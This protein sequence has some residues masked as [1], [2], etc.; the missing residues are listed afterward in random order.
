MDDQ[1]TCF[2]ILSRISFFLIIVIRYHKPSLV[3]LQGDC[4]LQPHLFF[5]L[6]TFIWKYC[7]LQ[8][9]IGKEIPQRWLANYAISANLK[10]SENIKCNLTINSATL[11][12]IENISYRQAFFQYGHIP[13]WKYVTNQTKVKQLHLDDKL[14]TFQWFRKFKF[15]M[16]LAFSLGTPKC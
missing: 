10:T 4:K 3:S 5:S 7:C 1:K 9:S 12:D 13:W 14:E 6:P 8:H 2:Q 15:Q 11:A 16:F